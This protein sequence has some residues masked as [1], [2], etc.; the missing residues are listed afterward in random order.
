MD[1]LKSYMKRINRVL[2]IPEGQMLSLR[3]PRNSVLLY[4]GVS[5]LLMREKEQQLV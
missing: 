1:A 4:S 2:F 3:C 5:A